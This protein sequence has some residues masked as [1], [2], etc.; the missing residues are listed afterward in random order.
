MITELKLQIQC[1]NTQKTQTFEQIM[2]KFVQINIEQ[3]HSLWKY[4]LQCIKLIKQ[5]F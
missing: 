5:M 1:L 4:W 2:K 3:V